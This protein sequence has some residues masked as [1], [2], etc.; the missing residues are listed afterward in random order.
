MATLPEEILEKIIDLAL[1]DCASIVRN[2]RGAGGHRAL[3]LVS[4]QFHR[5]TEPILYERP[6]R[7]YGTHDEHACG[8]MFRHSFWDWRDQYCTAPLSRFNKL[9]LHFH[10]ELSFLDLGV[11]WEDVVKHM[12]HRT[13]MQ[14][15]YAETNK[16]SQVM[17]ECG[18]P[19]LVEDGRMTVTIK[20]HDA[21]PFHDPVSHAD[22]EKTPSYRIP[23]WDRDHVSAILFEFRWLLQPIK[24]VPGIHQIISFPHLAWAVATSRD[25]TGRQLEPNFV[26]LAALRNWWNPDKYTQ[27]IPEDYQDFY[28]FLPFNDSTERWI[29][30]FDEPGYSSY[31]ISPRGVLQKLEPDDLRDWREDLDFCNFRMLKWNWG[32]ETI[33]HELVVVEDVWQV[34]YRQ[35]DNLDALEDDSAGPRKWRLML[36]HARIIAFNDI[37]REFSDELKCFRSPPREGRKPVTSIKEWKCNLHAQL[38]RLKTVGLWDGTWRTLYKFPGHRLVRSDEQLGKFWCQC[39]KKVDVDIGQSMKWQARQ[40]LDEKELERLLERRRWIDGEKPE[41]LR[42][43]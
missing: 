43:A 32:C 33:D 25:Y 14:G 19:K 16:L 8:G 28:N 22:P 40:G 6:L 4:K 11:L 1:P 20:F 26:L 3:F 9:E 42:T 39:G 23:L 35:L 15:I 36:T 30:S 17:L 21:C 13:L 31:S 29:D 2:G 5:I 41:L 7:L 34:L 37:F 12:D 24:T 27:T 38:G 10:P 18:I